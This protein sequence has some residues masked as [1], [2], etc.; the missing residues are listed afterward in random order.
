M[1]NAARVRSALGARSADASR[2]IGSNRPTVVHT[3]RAFRAIVRVGD[4]PRRD[5]PRPDFE[6]A[7]S[8]STV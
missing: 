1:S 4:D 6:P 3:S 2:H 5:R 7:K 8:S